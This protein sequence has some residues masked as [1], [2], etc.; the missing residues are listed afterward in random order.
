MFDFLLIVEHL[1]TFGAENLAVRLGFD[2][3][4]LGDEG[5]PFLAILFNH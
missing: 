4:D 2:V 3:F 5:F 1:P